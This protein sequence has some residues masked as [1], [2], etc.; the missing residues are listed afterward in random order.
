MSLQSSSSI[1]KL[2][3]NKRIGEKKIL[4]K[5]LVMYKTWIKARNQDKHPSPPYQTFMPTVN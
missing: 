1:R 5:A 2:F 4:G 3:E